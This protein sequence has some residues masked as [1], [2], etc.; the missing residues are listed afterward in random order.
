MKHVNDW[1]FRDIYKGGL[2]EDD[3]YV[4]V[5]LPL[6]MFLVALAAR[7]QKYRVMKFMHMKNVENLN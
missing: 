5:P 3:L 7:W 2:W 6:C 1:C 4:C